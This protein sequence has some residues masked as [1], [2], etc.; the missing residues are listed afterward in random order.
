MGDLRHVPSGC[1]VKAPSTRR[2]TFACYPPLPLDR[3]CEARVDP[4]IS[5]TGMGPTT[6]ES[7]PPA[8]TNRSTRPASE[9][10]LDTRWGSIGGLTVTHSMAK[11]CATVSRDDS[12]PSVLGSARFGGVCVL[13]M[14]SGTEETHTLSSN[15]IRVARPKQSPMNR[16]A[17]RLTK[18]S[19][20]CSAHSSLSWT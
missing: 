16:P 6:S 13:P 17:Q 2:T 20:F 1:L 9:S 5:R 14:T 7:T 15:G 18:A 8:H 12:Y 19:C 11:Y 3:G 10:Y 4:E